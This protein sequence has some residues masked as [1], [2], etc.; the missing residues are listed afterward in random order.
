MSDNKQ[1]RSLKEN[2]QMIAR[3][4]KIL[5]QIGAQSHGDI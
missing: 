2:L 1:K 3:T 4:M 5:Y